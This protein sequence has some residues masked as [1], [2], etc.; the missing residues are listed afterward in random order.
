MRCRI[1]LTS[2]G[3]FRIVKFLFTVAFPIAQK[4]ES[5]VQVNTSNEKASLCCLSS[6]QINPVSWKPSSY[7]TKLHS[8]MQCFGKRNR[9]VMFTG[10]STF[11]INIH[12]WE[13]YEEFWKSVTSDKK[14]IFFSIFFLSPRVKDSCCFVNFVLEEVLFSGEH[15]PDSV[16]YISEFTFVSFGL[17]K[18][19]FLYLN[20]S[21][22]FLRKLNV[23]LFDCHLWGSL[24]PAL[25]LVLFHPLAI[26]VMLAVLH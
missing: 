24:L 21:L 9:W 7:T 17:F 12:L 10:G 13:F 2:I 8:K 18:F 1:I 15:F 16:T 22:Q 23:W 5:V 3:H 26:T 20:Q 4:S 11:W 6:E 25:W 19:P 14:S